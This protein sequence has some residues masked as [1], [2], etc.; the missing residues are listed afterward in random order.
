MEI[1]AQA[2]FQRIAPKKA[3]IATGLIRGKKV[4]EAIHIL[5]S[6]PK[7][8]ADFVLKVLKSAEANAKNNKNLK[9][10]NLIIKDSYVDGGPTLKRWRPRAF[11]RASLIM[12]RT[13]HITVVLEEINPN[14]NKKEEDLKSKKSEATINHGKGKIQ[15][16]KDEKMNKEKSYAK[17]ILAARGR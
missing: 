7:K 13:S 3:R 8:S 16:S 17:K 12:K 2:K 9:S 1:R 10:E 11:G 5:D 4:Q 6:L 15:I 14:K